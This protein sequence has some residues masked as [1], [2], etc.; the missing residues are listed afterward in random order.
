MN[1]KIDSLPLIENSPVEP[2]FDLSEHLESRIK[3]PNFIMI[4]IGHDSLPVAYQ[5]PFEFRGKRAYIGLEAWL[6]DPIGVKKECIRELRETVE[7]G[8]NVFYMSYDT[9]GVIER[10][11]YEEEGGYSWYRGNYDT[12]S[13]LPKEVAQEVFI[14]NVFCDPHIASSKER[15]TSLLSEAARVIDAGGIIVLRETITPEKVMHLNENLLKKLSLKIQ[16]T[17]VPESLAEWELLE[18]IYKAEPYPVRPETGSYYMFLSKDS[19]NSDS[20]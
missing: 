13:I 7:N 18:T 11:G 5:Q 2:S 6:R 8:Q 16:K 19:D 4:E 15:T 9:G 1:S 17:I 12:S 10:D 20:L 14:S 3:D